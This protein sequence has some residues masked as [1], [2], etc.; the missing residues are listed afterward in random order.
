MGWELENRVLAY[1]RRAAAVRGRGELGRAQ[2][3]VGLSKTYIRSIPADRFAVSKLR[4][5]SEGL[6][7]D[8]REAFRYAMDTGGVRLFIEDGQRLAPEVKDY[9]KSVR[10]TVNRMRA[11]WE[12]QSGGVDLDAIDAQRYEDPQ[13]ALSAIEDALGVVSGPKTYAKALGIWGSAQ[14]GVYRLDYATMGI[15]LAIEAAQAACDREVLAVL[16]Q[17]AAYALRD[18]GELDWALEVSDA[19]LELRTSLGDFDFLGRAYIVHGSLL[20]SAG[21]PASSIRC[22]RAGLIFLDEEN[23]RL[24]R[25]TA[26]Q[27]LSL[28]YSAR[29]ELKSADEA[30]WSAHSVGVSSS[31]LLGRLAWSQGRMA[32]QS[33]HFVA[34]IDHYRDALKLL[35]P[36]SVDAALVGA[37]FVRVLLEAGRHQE[38]QQVSVGLSTLADAVNEHPMDFDQAISAALLDLALAGVETK[39]ST[40][41]V[42]R[43]VEAIEQGR[44]AAATRLQRELCL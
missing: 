9:P 32:R 42:S 18:R 19:M 8:A 24:W 22:C 27:T 1:V 33:A 36:E 4:L 11:W 44:A 3:R 2:V 26:L 31:G 10:D 13:G 25:F 43:V 39:V 12:E 6:G 40:R 30:A 17:R 14:A 34:S 21:D 20:S 7:M 29:G 41:V 28:A 35:L 23:S 37:E 16:L 38:A 5:I 15:G